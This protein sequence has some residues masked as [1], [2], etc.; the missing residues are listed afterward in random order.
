MY[1]I[2]LLAFSSEGIFG[3]PFIVPVAGCAMVLGI[4][5]AGIWSGIRTR[6]IEGQERLAAIAK[7]I[8]PP[9]TPAELA[10]IHGRP[11]AN[12]SKRRAN[13]RRSGI[14]LLFTGVGLALFFV[15][16]AIVVQVR[17]VLSGA[18]A[19]LIPLSIG[20]GFLIDAKIQTRELADSQANR[21]I[22]PVELVR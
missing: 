9:P 20:I 3:S 22:A 13:S 4:V 19:A 17:E 18:A 12:L 6:E 2:S 14:V 15:V 16:L 11:D 21:S 5:V 10:V 8:A 1:A 7:G